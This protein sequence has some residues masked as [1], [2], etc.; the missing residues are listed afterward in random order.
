MWRHILFPWTALAF[1]GK[2]IL[3]HPTMTRADVDAQFTQW[4]VKAPACHMIFLP[5]GNSNAQ[6]TVIVKG[7][8]MTWHGEDAV[9]CV[10]CFMHLMAAK[11]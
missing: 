8:H 6:C 4:K 3:V 11:T 1:H 10:D 2:L 7:R 9:D 5:I